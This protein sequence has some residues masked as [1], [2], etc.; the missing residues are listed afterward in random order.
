MVQV[1]SLKFLFV[2]GESRAGSD[3]ETGL[4]VAVAR[5]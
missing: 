3:G 1:V 5:T 2:G 4:V